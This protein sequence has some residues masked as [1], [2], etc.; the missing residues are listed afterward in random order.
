MADEFI[1][2]LWTYNI[3]SGLLISPFVIAIFFVKSFAVIPLLKIVI[4]GAILL[5]IVKIIRWIEILIT[6]RVSIL[7]MISRAQRY[8]IIYKIETLC[9]INISIHLIILTIISKIAPNITI[10]NRGITAKDFTKKIAITKGEIKSPDKI[11]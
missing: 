10:F 1:V 6:H 2:N 8:K 5:M 9:V 11:L 4:F 3:L 7:Y